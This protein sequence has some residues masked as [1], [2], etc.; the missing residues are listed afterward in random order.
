MDRKRI[1]G[2]RAEYEKLV[3]LGICG[4]MAKSYL[5]VTNLLSTIPDL[6]D[7]INE[8][9]RKCITCQQHLI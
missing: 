6:L 7:Y 9:E 8:L 5:P 2:I 4:G 1:E 3:E